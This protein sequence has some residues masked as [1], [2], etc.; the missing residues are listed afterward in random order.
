V[1]F[2]LKNW[3]SQRQLRF[4]R[5]DSVKSIIAQ[6]GQYSQRLDG[7]SALRQAGCGFFAANFPVC[8]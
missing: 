4:K 2:Q 8:G 6:T 7:C 3:R 1:H 5:H